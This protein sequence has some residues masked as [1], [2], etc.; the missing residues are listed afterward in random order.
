MDIIINKNHKK[1]YYTSQIKK[2]FA[3]K[4]SIS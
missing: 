2:I 3:N 1:I 4:I